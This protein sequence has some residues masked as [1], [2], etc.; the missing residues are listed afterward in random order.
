MPGVCA[1]FV[2]TEPPPVVGAAYTC[3]NRKALKLTER[4][5]DGRRDATRTPTRAPL[6]PGG[7]WF[8]YVMKYV[9]IDVW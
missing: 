3:H 1:A 5:Q 8:G 7:P 4:R 2:V 6:R 9:A